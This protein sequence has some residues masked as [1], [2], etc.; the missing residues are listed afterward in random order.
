MNEVF[1]LSRLG[2]RSGNGVFLS[3]K[4]SFG[5]LALAAALVVLYFI[6]RSNYLLFHVIVEVFSIIV[7]CGVFMIAWNSRRFHQNGFFLCLGVASLFVAGVDLLH[8]LAYKNMGVFPENGA[9]LPTQL[10]IVAR[11]LEAAAFL[12]APVFLSRRASP[13]LLLG[14]YLGVTTVLL[15]A[16]FGGL[17]PDCFREGT[18]LTLSRSPANT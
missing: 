13:S 2:Y 5:P 18:G 3:A 6:S 15:A 8:T 1:L 10:W 12:L 4:G 17:F 9:N 11:Y 16:V 7:A 14:S